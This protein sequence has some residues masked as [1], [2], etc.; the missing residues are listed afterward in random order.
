[1]VDESY[2][3]FTTTQS[4][5]GIYHPIQPENHRKGEGAREKKL[6]TVFNF[7]IVDF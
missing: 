4:N 3:N 5:K 1:M 2:S 6:A 7:Y